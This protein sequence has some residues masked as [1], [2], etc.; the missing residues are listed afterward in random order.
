MASVSHLLNWE[1]EKK[2]QNGV[3]VGNWETCGVFLIHTDMPGYLFQCVWVPVPASEALQCED[4]F[5][6]QNYT[7]PK[8]G[9]E[10]CILLYLRQK[11]RPAGLSICRA[12]LS[13][14]KCAGDRSYSSPL[15]VLFCDC[16][17]GCESWGQQPGPG[18]CPF[19]GRSE[20]P[21]RTGETSFYHLGSCP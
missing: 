20:E 15:L 18:K 5:A 16:S 17:F 4:S 10:C 2:H 19:L 7:F 21:T 1:A 11:A 14:R 9:R 3:P 12:C 13:S 6:P 8:S